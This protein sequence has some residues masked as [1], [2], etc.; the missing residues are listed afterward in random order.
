[1]KKNP[2]Q[3]RYILFHKPY[4]VLCQF[5]D[6]AG[7]KTL[8]DFGPFPKRVYPVGRLDADSEGLLLL[9]DDGL[10]KHLFLEPRYRHPRTYLAQVERTPTEDALAELRRGV[11][12]E[13]KKTLPAKVELLDVVPAVPSRVIPIRFRKSIATSWLEFTL[14]EGRNRQVRKMTAAVGH[15]T[16]RL[17]R[18]AI[19][20]LTLGNLQPGETREITPQEAAKLQRFVEKHSRYRS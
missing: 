10:L 12:I 4:A 5:T 15:P 13:G 20:P 9:T 1:M 11:L 16:L 3:R 14:S 19:G 8:A 6:T 7:R 18:I 17:I 2:L